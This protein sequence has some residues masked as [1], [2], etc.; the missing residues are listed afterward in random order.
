MDK[1]NHP[2]GCQCKTCVRGERCS[3]CHGHRRFRLFFLLRLLVMIAI[4]A[5][6]FSCGYKLGALKS[7]FN[8]E[9]RGYPTMMQN[10]FGSGLQPGSVPYS[11]GPT[12]MPTSTPK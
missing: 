11:A 9:Y 3:C 12:K 1:N 5:L 10:G 2:E 6:V 4:L 8:R 7:S